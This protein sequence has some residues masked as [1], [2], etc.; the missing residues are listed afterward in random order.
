[1]GG[2]CAVT[3][4]AML[5]MLIKE[6]S[7]VVNDDDGGGDDEDDDDCGTAG[8]QE[9]ITRERMERRPRHQRADGASILSRT[10]SSPKAHF[11]NWGI[12]PPK[13]NSDA[14]E[15]GAWCPFAGTK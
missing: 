7:S 1:M 14:T 3:G 4:Q 6:Y 9:C 13:S 2:E 12:N 11:F 5:M 15:E 10:G 8:V